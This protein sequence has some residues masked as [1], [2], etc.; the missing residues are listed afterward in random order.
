MLASEYDE[1]WTRTKKKIE[2]EVIW[3]TLGVDREGEWKSHDPEFCRCFLY[4]QRT[5]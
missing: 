2:S 3:T 5:K 4:Y 1:R